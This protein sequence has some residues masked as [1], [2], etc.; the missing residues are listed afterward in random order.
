MMKKALLAGLS[1]IALST[2]AAAED[3]P[4]GRLGDAAVPQAYRL[5]LTVAPETTEFSGHTEIDVTLPRATSVLYIHGNGLKV[6]KASASAGGKTIAATYSDVDPSGVAKLVFAAPVP[7]GKAT[8]SFDYSAP[9]QE[10]GEGL[11]R[12]KAGDDWYAWTQMEPIDARRM[13]PSFDEPGFKTPF[14]VSII[15]KEG[16]KAFANTPEVKAMAVA[17]G[18][19]RHDFA[20]S[21]PLPTYLVAIAVGPFD[22]VEGPAPA[23]AVR[24]RALPYRVIATKGQAPRLKTAAE[25]GP[26][27]LAL[28]EDYFGSP[29]P[30]EK[31]DQIASP[32]MGGAMENA[33]LVTYNDTLLL[34]DPD[35]PISQQRNFGTVVAHELAHQWFGDLVTP[36]WWTDIWLNESFAEWLG[37]RVSEQWR[38]GLGAR[39]LQLADAFE[40]M[41][42]DSRTAGRPIRQEITHNNQI[43]SAFDSITYQKGGQVLGMFEAYLGPDRFREGVRYHLGRFRYGSASAEDFFKSLGDSARDPELVPAFQSFVNQTGVPVVKITKAGSGWSIAQERYRPLGVAAGTP[44]LWSI[45]VCARQGDATSCTLLKQDSG[46]LTLTGSGVAVPNPD[47]AGYYRYRLDDSGWAALMAKADT[48]PAR[49]AMAAADSL[50][51]GFRAGNA[52]FERVLASARILAN[53]PERIAATELPVRISG[54]S[55][56]VLPAASLPRYRTLMAEL[57]GARLAALGF[58]PKRGAYAAEDND[59]RQLRQTLVGLTATEAR[60]PAVRAKLTAAA[61]A[62][63]AGDEAALDP[64][65]RPVAFRVA[66]EEGG[67]AFMDKLRDALIA[68]RDPLFRQQAVSGIASGQTLPLVQHAITLSADERLQS[69][70]RLYLVFLTRQS[71][72]GR[73]TLMTGLT[74]DFDAF[75]APVPAMFRPRL[76]T[77]FEGYCD[78]SKAEAVDRLM[79]PKVAKLGGGE[80]ELAQTLESIRLCAALKEAKGAEIAA[81][82][83]P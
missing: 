34:L 70:E 19:V 38:P 83:A 40:A 62:A 67:V 31:L 43:A 63:V 15:A 10:A 23:N 44:Q 60:D 55:E 24:A 18:M 4:A 20:A 12:A 78:A 26:K 46:T 52:S 79:R 42:T 36:T 77:L 3:V 61:Q 66:V 82:L 13:F 35:A 37:N 14:S 30:F 56:S 59:R 22:A 68:S 57:F 32:I 49:E 80:L 21:R 73:D 54:I 6:G 48:L 1:A 11:Y 2:T 51:A 74:T 76:S 64:S 27:I 9:F 5:S 25:E 33:G 71:E 45:P 53:H 17:G 72:A 58:D 29:Y 8:L 7:A 39:V 75:A 47:G 28:L 16:L 65:Y 81:A 69:M 50:W 41:D